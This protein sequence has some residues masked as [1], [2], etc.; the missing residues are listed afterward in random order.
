MVQKNY[1]YYYIIGDRKGFVRIKDDEVSIAIVKNE[2]NAGLGTAA[3]NEVAK[4]HPN[5]KAQVKLNNIQSLNFFINAG[6]KP[7]GFILEKT[8]SK[9]EKK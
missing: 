7:A 9:K 6:F 2:Q 4:I 1:E 8:N 5:L 3:L